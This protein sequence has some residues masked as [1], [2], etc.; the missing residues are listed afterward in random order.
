MSALKIIRRGKEVDLYVD[1]KKTEPV[2]KVKLMKTMSRKE[3]DKLIE[4]KRAEQRKES[5]E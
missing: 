5:S 2:E 3:L 1:G 4:Q